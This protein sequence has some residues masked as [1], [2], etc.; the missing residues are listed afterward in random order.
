MEANRISGPSYRASAQDSRTPD[1]TSDDP[2]SIADDD[3]LDHSEMKFKLSPKLMCHDRVPRHA[4]F[5]VFS[6]SSK[7]SQA[8]LRTP[9][10]SLFLYCGEHDEC[11]F[12]ELISKIIK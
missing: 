7:L 8:P 6:A 11:I 9:H 1:E 10:L 5:P 2:N 3:R 4:S 12:F